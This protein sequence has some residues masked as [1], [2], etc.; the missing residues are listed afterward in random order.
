MPTLFFPD[1]QT[2]RHVLAQGIV[3]SSISQFPVTVHLDTQGQYRLTS[4]IPISDEVIFGIVQHGG[5]LLSGPAPIDGETFECW[6]QLIPLEPVSLPPGSLTSRVLFDLPGNEL[7]RLAGE[8]HRLAKE[9]LELAWS[10]DLE[11][12][13]SESLRV[14]ARVTSH[15]ISPCRAY[16]S[17][18]IPQAPVPTL[19]MARQV[20]VRA[21]YRHPLVDQI[22]VPA[23]K[24]LFLR[25]PRSW[26]IVDDRHWV[27]AVPSF[28]VA[29]AAAQHRKSTGLAEAA[30][31]GTHRDRGKLVTP[32][33]LVPFAD[34]DTPELWAIPENALAAALRTGPNLRPANAHPSLVC[35]FFNRVRP[36][37]LDPGRRSK[38][39]LPVLLP[40]VL[41]YKTVLKLPNLYIPCDY[42]LRPTLRRDA[43]RQLLAPDARRLTWLRMLPDGSFRPETLPMTAFHPLAEWVQYR[44]DA[45]PRIRS[46]WMQAEDWSFERF[47]VRPEL[48]RRQ[49]PAPEAASVPA[50]PPVSIPEPVTAKSGLLGRVFSWL[51]SRKPQIQATETQEPATIPIATAVPAA[52]QFPQINLLPRMLVLRRCDSAANNWNRGFSR[53]CLN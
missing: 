17:K 3:P 37:G 16:S 47:S 4:S 14:W 7:S 2:L 29:G 46:A 53:N 43:L 34:Q 42:R 50:P 21:G 25:P 39:V 45:S 41:A 30:A 35:C 49:L 19:K 28:A 36:N 52:L 22:L 40:G 5:R 8:I 51:T 10:T 48:S 20:W 15:P 12:D 6:H 33:R 38:G 23:E 24:L 44:I 27:G 32:L 11:Q 31:R 1:L 18:P 26:E 9:T 13:D